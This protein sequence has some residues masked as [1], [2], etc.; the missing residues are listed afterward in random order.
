MASDFWSGREDAFSGKKAL[1]L[2]G[3]GFLGSSLA[4]RLCEMGAEVLLAD[5]V[6]EEYGGNLFNIAPIRERVRVNFS[7]IRDEHAMAQLV[8]GQDYVFHCAA[9]VCHLKSLTNP[10]PDIDINIR[11]TAVVLEAL[12]QYNPAAK[13]VKL[14]SRG[15][16]GTVASLPAAEEARPDP[17]GIYEI[18]LLAAEHMAAAYAR[19]HGVRCVLTRL[20]NIY[21]PRAQMRHNRFGVANWFVRLAIDGQIIPVFGDGQIKRDFL[22]ADDCVEA[23]LRLAALPEAEGQLFNVGHDQPSNFLE[24]A[25]TIVEVAGTGSY[26][27][28]PFSPER[29]AQEPGDFYTDITK[30]SQVTGWRPT[31]SLQDGVRRTVEYY[32]A[33]KEHYW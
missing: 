23:L 26:R 25:R 27:F 24:L 11:G 17:R 15:Q 28:A 3:L 32:R 5:A 10:F 21:G 20:T 22:Y 9:Q 6:L 18:S 31:V 7:D 8:E 19:N 30:I 13:L 1:I 12:R 4:I 29:K 2:G 14:G 33:H 16:Y